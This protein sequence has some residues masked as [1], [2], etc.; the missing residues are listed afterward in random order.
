MS[1]T[2]PKNP[3][4]S[5]RE[6][7]LDAANRRFRQ[8]GYTKTTM[9]E[10]ATDVDMS[11]A[12][13]YRYFENKL[14]IGAGLALRCF[15]EKESLLRE[16]VERPGQSA[17]Q[18][19]EDF[20]LTLVRYTHGQ[21]HASPRINEVVEDIAS[22]RADIVRRKHQGEHD[23]VAEILRQGVQSGEFAIADISATADTVI[24][25]LLLFS[26]PI[27]MQAHPLERFEAMARD[28]ARLLIRGLSRLD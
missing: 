8:F 23:L 22:H 15:A 3:L 2:D 1:M 19:L 13:L 6:R 20:L 14:D 7:I 5:T 11:A 28:T 16:V 25:S 21:C 17:G 12:N 27:F 18:R 4:D 10:I 26:M 24:N 9:A